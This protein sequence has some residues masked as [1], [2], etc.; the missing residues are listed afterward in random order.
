MSKLDKKITNPQEHAK[1]LDAGKGVLQ[2]V[3]ELGLSIREA[4]AQG[5]ISEK[6]AESAQIAADEAARL[7]RKE[8][9][10]K[11]TEEQEH[12]KQER[13]RQE[14]ENEEQRKRE[15]QLQ[16]EQAER[17]AR[18]RATEVAVNQLMNEL[19]PDCTRR[20]T[21]ANDG[22]KNID[23]LVQRLNADE[24]RKRNGTITI[25]DHFNLKIHIH[26]ARLLSRN[27]RAEKAAKETVQ[28]AK[29]KIGQWCKD[30][31][32]SAPSPYGWSDTE[33]GTKVEINLREAM[34]KLEPMESE[35]YRE[36][37]AADQEVGPGGEFMRGGLD[38]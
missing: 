32:S 5:M 31:R 18:E 21:D 25:E 33:L 29:E 38:N 6:E 2:T 17:D 16:Q 3:Q 24:E 15:L 37:P 30:N 1:T 14:K 9:K 12:R 34:Q 13:L 10:R 28:S 4:L 7:A 23:D 8:D 27:R 36:I 35:A 19:M 20:F 11:K 22:R 26:N